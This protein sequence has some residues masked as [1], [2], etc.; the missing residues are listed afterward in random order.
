MEQQLLAFGLNPGDYH[1]KKFGSGHINHTFLVEPLSGGKAWILQKIN[2]FVFKKPEDI[3]RN[4]EKTAD[5][6]ASSFPDYLFISPARTTDGK[7]LL[8]TNGE[9][10]RLSPFIPGSESFNEATAPEQAY[11]AARQFGVLTRNLHHMDIAGLNPTIP[12]F[13]DLALR[14]RQFCEAA[15]G[16]LPERKEA[17]ADL[18]EAYESRK[19]LVDTYTDILQDKSYPE[20]M[21][22]H[23][24]KINNVL[25]DIKTG[26]GLCVC[27]LDTLMPGRIISDLGDMVRTYVC[28]ENEES[29]AFDRIV[30]R[31]DY[32][33]ALMRGY[34]TEMKDLLTPSEKAGLFYAGQFM[35]YMQGLRFLSDFL[36]NDVY[37]PVK[38]PQHN[39][40][41]ARNQLILLQDLEGRKEYLEGLIRSCLE[42]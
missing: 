4:L 1:L 20:R 29:T 13:H 33:E 23:D 10:W 6:L 37:Y 5:F 31:E 42:Q 21:M 24:T 22:H 26:K 39:L 25:F 35:I 14:Y 41:R 2:T 15:E 34:L 7:S 30:V 11:E 17:A 32:F 3:A 8:E 28:E 36:N 19:A 27:D 18:I 38:Y 16:A 40:N 9:Y 12:G